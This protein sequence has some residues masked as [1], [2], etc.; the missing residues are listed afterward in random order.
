VCEW[1]SGKN[2]EALAS[3]ARARNLSRAYESEASMRAALFL[4]PGQLAMVREML[5]AERRA[6]PPAE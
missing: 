4:S 2:Q 6:S 1:K 3:F 5:S